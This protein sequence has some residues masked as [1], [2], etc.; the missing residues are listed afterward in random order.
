MLHADK[1]DSDQT[2]RNLQGD[3]IFRCAHI[4]EGRLSDVAV[5]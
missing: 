3:F 4:P 1:K 2:A 5:P